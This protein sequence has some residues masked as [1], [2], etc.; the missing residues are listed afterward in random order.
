MNN[1]KRGAYDGYK[2]RVVFQIMKY[3]MLSL[4]LN[5]KYLPNEE[6]WGSKNVHIE[7]Y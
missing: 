2:N 1:R 6:R 5:E 7:Q 4:V 3:L